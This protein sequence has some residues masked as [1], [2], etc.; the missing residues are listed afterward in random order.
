MHPLEK[1]FMAHTIEKTEQATDWYDEICQQLDLL[2][3]D[4]KN[5]PSPEEIAPSDTLFAIVKNEF[6][7]I[8]QLAGFPDIP[9]PDVWLGPEGDIGLTW[10]FDDSSFD[11]IFG[12]ERFVARLT[13]ALKQQL[14][15]RKDVPCTLKKLVA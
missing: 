10:D 12:N 6:Q 4:S 14:I 11:M 15:E 9:A 1:L 5:H 7:I 13:V 8:R 3:E 2:R